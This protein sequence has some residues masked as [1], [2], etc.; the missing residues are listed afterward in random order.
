[1]KNKLI[2]IGTTFIIVLVCFFAKTNT[3]QVALN[4]KEDEFYRQ[5]NKCNKKE[6]A[7]SFN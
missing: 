4:I 2:V 7:N 6:L 3:V 1:M 5:D